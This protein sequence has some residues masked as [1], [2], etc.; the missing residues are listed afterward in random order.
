MIK[1]VIFTASMIYYFLSGQ[2]VIKI[3]HCSVV[4][5][6]H[7]ANVHFVNYNKC[8]LINIWPNRTKNLIL[9]TYSKFFFVFDMDLFT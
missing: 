6:N 5:Q 7:V 4:N 2:M 9:S 3:N 1:S 8:T